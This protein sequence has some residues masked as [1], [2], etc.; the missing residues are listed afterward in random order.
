MCRRVV[1]M[2]DMTIPPMS[3]ATIP[4]RIEMNRIAEAGADRLWT[5]E[6]N[7][8]RSGISVARAIMPQRLNNVPVLVLNSSKVSKK[9]SAE[10]VLSKLSVAEW[11]ESGNL[12]GDGDVDEYEHLNKLL[13]GI[14]NS[15]TD[16]RIN[17]LKDTL[18][19]YSDVC[20]K[21]K[22][23]F[24]E[25]SLAK[26][27]IDTGNAR[28]MRQTPKRQPFHLLDKING[29]VQDMLEAGVIEPSSSPW[30]SNIVVV[31]KKDDSLR[32]CVDNRR[33]NSVTRRDAYPLPRIDSCWMLLVGRTSLV[34]SIYNL[35]TIRC[36]CKKRIQIRLV[37][38]YRRA[39]IG[40]R[41]FRLVCATQGV[42]SSK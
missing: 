17:R 5:T 22:L 32:Y 29:Y 24:G 35:G 18:R 12:E 27:R 31:K 11:I 38:S 6:A 2:E 42:P 14:D 9:I 3:Q 39:R 36:P 1:A 21:G 26:H 19:R 8:L 4:G 41:E 15:V 34:L 16:E 28:P 23:D 30:A 25:T 7:D 40:S 37:S 20:S 10:T 13:E 33:L